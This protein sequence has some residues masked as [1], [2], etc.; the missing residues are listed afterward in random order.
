MPGR[1]M[2]NNNYLATIRQK[3]GVEWEGEGNM[4]DR[5]ASPLIWDNILG[6]GHEWKKHKTGNFE[7][8]PAD[9]DGD[10]RRDRDYCYVS[11]T[12]IWDQ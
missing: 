3:Y 1:G 9:L 2:Y 12:P 6:I 7:L 10:R 8:V 4:S 5:R 11:V